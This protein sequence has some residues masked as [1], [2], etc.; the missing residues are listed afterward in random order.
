MNRRYGMIAATLLLVAGCDTLGSLGGGVTSVGQTA[1]NYRPGDYSAAG[2]NRDMWVIVAGTVGGADASA[3]QQKTIATMQRNAGIPTR[4]TATPQNHNRVYKTVLMFNGPDSLP[5]NELC[6]NPGAQSAAAA[7]TSGLRLHAVFCR[8]D[9][10]LTEVRSRAQGDNSLNNPNF[11]AL[12][13]QT[14]TDM[15][16]ASRDNQRDEPSN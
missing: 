14:M 3:L 2:N 13:R 7:A 1:S 9:Q 4:F 15:Y 10:F 5:G 12:I 8:N 6:R 16:T 11:D